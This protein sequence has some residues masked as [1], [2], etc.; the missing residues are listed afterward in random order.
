MKNAKEYYKRT[1]NLDENFN[2]KKFILM[3]IEPNT[4]IDL[5]CGAGRDTIFLIKKGWQVISIDK[6]DTSSI[7]RN[8]LDDNE[9]K[10]FKFICQ[11]F[12]E[13]NLKQNN[14]LVANY[15]LPFC[16]KNYVPTLWKN[17]CNS[18]NINRLFCRKLFRN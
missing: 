4:A 3:N 9:K 11:D 1:E 14:L 13:L 17:I 16:N 7:I 10:R 5:G 8:K 2:L 12:E 18:I 15:S 6:V